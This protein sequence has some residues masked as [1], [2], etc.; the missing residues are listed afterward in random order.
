MPIKKS[1][2][3]HVTCAKA[4]EPI[5]APK[6]RSS[7]NKPPRQ[8]SHWVR[9]ERSRYRQELSLAANNI[10][11]RLLCVGVEQMVTVP[12]GATLKSDILFYLFILFSDYVDILF[13]Y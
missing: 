9:R 13:I 1:R 5:G 12:I 7:A 3:W 6:S 2:Q 4:I 10:A 11:A 8:R